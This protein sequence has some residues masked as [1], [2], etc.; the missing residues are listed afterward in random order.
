MDNIHNTQSVQSIQLLRKLEGEFTQPY[1]DKIA[2]LERELA[3]AKAQFQQLRAKIPNSFIELLNQEQPDE[4][5]YRIKGKEIHDKLNQIAIARYPRLAS[6]AGRA[7]SKNPT[8]QLVQ[9]LLEYVVDGEIRFCR[10]NSML[11]NNEIR[12]MDG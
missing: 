10:L 6:Q 8:T 12:I 7:T 9:D 2:T 11:L 4:K 5:V 1:E 3:A